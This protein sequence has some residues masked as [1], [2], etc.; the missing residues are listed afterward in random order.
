MLLAKRAQ[1]ASKSVEHANATTAT[2]GSV[3]MSISSQTGILINDSGRNSTD[4]KSTRG[5]KSM[6]IDDA[7]SS[8]LGKQQ[9]I[10]FSRVRNKAVFS[11]T[12]AVS[13]NSSSFASVWSPISSEENFS[14]IEQLNTGNKSSPAK[15]LSPRTEKA[16][17]DNPEM[18][19]L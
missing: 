19:T 15:L 16:F 10:G 6:S 3:G 17:N 5:S 12:A 4:K 14:S 7:S 18:Q 11:S 2:N 1:S 8:N 9:R 13:N